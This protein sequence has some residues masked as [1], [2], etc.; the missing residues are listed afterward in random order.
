MANSECNTRFLCNRFNSIYSCKTKLKE[1][2]FYRY[3]L[4]NQSARVWLNRI[5]AGLPP[6]IPPFSGESCRCSG[7]IKSPVP[8]PYKPQG[9]KHWISFFG[10]EDGNGLGTCYQ[11]ILQSG[12]A[13]TALTWTPEGWS[14]R[15]WPGT[16]WRRTIL[17]VMKSPGIGW[18]KA[19][20]S[21]Q[22]RA[23][24]QN[25]IEALCATGHDEVEWVWVCNGFI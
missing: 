22:D 17:V 3:Y 14:K 9:K 25:L 6:S 23:A 20:R 8:H 16:T 13:R 15:G 4:T 1:V 12:H 11:W 21:A 18:E 5:I 10:K 7:L 19:I 24:R 2:M